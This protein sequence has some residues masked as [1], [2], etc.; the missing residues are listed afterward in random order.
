MPSDGCCG[1][2]RAGVCGVRREK[3]AGESVS[4]DFYTTDSVSVSG[5]GS[6]G[7]QSAS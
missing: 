7:T 6:L 4:I 3:N 1:G 2:E 5:H